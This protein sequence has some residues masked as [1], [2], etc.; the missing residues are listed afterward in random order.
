[1]PYCGISFEMATCLCPSALVPVLLCEVTAGCPTEILK[2]EGVTLA[3]GFKGFL[4]VYYCRE[5]KMVRTVLGGRN[6]GEAYSVAVNR[7]WRTQAGTRGD[8]NPTRPI[9]S[10]Q[11]LLARPCFLEVSVFRGSLQ[12]LYGLQGA[13]QIPSSSGW[14]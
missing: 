7:E 13:F 5:C 12:A 9:P 4:P 1:M 8:R 10:D 3:H 11:L 6:V 14:L 2:E